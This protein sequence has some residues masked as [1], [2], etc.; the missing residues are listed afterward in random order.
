[1]KGAGILEYHLGG[2]VEHLDEHW[3]KES[4][5]LALSAKT[6]INDVIPKFEKLLNMNFRSYHTP[7]A[8][9]YHPELD[10]SPLMNLE[11]ASRFP[12]PSW[13]YQLDRHTW[14]I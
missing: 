14:Q 1:M 7:M 8:E 4:I 11:D 5:C 13:Q 3:I 10:D 9:G 2:D 6:Y 12:I